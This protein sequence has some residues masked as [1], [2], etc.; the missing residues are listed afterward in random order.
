[1]L[2]PLP[3]QSK[4]QSSHQKENTMNIRTTTRGAR[5]RTLAVAGAAAVAL[6]LA[7]C[8]GGGGATPTSSSTDKGG[9]SSSLEKKVADFMKP[10]D[11]YTMPTEAVKDGNALK[12]KTLHYIPIA[13]QAPQFSL[14]AQV[15]KTAAAAVGADLRVCDGAGTPPTIAQ[16]IDGAINDSTTG[17]IILD[18]FFLGMA[19]NSVAAAQAA[20]I[21]VISSNQAVNDAFPASKTLGYVTAPGRQMFVEVA[22]WISLDSGGKANE[23]VLQSADGP[24][25]KTFIAS[26]M[27]EVKKDCPDCTISTLD[28]TSANFGKI[29]S[30]LSSKLLSDPNIDY[31]NA[32]FAQ[33][34]PVVLPVVGGKN[35]KVGTGASTL[36]ALQA[37]AGGQVAAASGQSA[38]FGA[39]ALVDIA[40]RM[41]NGQKVFDYELPTRL[42]TAD[43]IKDVTLTEAAEASGEWYGPTTFTDDFKKLWGLA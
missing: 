14:T 43:N 29:S 12:G 2:H 15:L 36:G 41:V 16:C 20:G 42:F 34:L 30:D 8:S 4:N 23:L 11:S 10:R 33:F 13:I 40:L 5:L 22:S 26:G 35:I 32:Q 25:Q 27:D 9:D 7:G 19:A 6:V 18:G 39:W 21:P 31:V 3:M 24:I 1:M 17:A 38:T 37:V 28:A